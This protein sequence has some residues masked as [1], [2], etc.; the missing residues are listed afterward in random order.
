MRRLLRSLGTLIVL[1]ILILASAMVYSTVRG[2]TRWYFRVNGQVTIDGRKTTGYMHANTERTM[3]LLTR[4]DGARPE[5][6]LVPF[7]DRQV[8]LDCGDWHPVRLLPSP[9]GDMSPPCSVFT[10]PATLKDP[11]I[12]GTLRRKAGS[13]EFST[14]SG[15]KV[16]AEW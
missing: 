11:A 10:D 6:Y 7:R 16:K 4:T 8:V 1:G 5:T 13:V 2:Y 9:V 14:A 15:K 3:L 12:S